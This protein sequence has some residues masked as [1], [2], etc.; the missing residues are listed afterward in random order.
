L[1]KIPV[2]NYL[3]FVCKP[4]HPQTMVGQQHVS[5]LYEKSL[6]IFLNKSQHSKYRIMTLTAVGLANNIF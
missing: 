4:A 6:R 1:V 5:S 2:S 3:F